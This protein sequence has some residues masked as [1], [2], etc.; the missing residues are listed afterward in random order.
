MGHGMLSVQC[1]KLVRVQLLEG[2]G[3]VVFSQLV[4]E[5]LLAQSGTKVIKLGKLKR[6]GKPEIKDTAHSAEVT[7]Q[8]PH[9]VSSQSPPNRT[10]N[11]SE[12]VSES[13]I[14][15]QTWRKGCG[16]MP[17][18]M[19]VGAAEGCPLADAGRLVWCH[20]GFCV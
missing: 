20:P 3:L 15:N 2:L 18:G 10:P 8:Q 14:G 5:K 13:G 7:A 17:G 6:S 1:L 11:S 12:S 9:F 4:S 19:Q 16:V